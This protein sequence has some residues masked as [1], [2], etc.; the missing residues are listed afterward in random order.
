MVA[1]V[2]SSPLLHGY[3]GA[4]QADVQALA[5]A[6][7]GLSDFAMAAGATLESVDV[8]PFVVL[9]EGRGAMA[10]DAVVTGR[11]REA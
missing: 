2:K 8:N 6:I 1:E 11:G 5:R 7:V 10:L 3:R 4:P 9:P